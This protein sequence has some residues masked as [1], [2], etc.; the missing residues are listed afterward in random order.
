[1]SYLVK[2]LRLGGLV[3][4]DVVTIMGGEGLSAYEIAPELNEA[5]EA[6]WKTPWGDSGDTD[7]LR[8]VSEPFSPEGG[9]KVL[10]GN[11]G[12]GVIKISAVDPANR[13]I[14]APAVV[15]ESQDDLITAFKRGELDKDFVAVVRFQGPCA[16]GMP[17]LHKMT[18]PLGLL[19]DRGFK[20]ALVTDGRMSGASGKVPAAIHIS[21]E[22]KNSGL[23]SK[24]QTGDMIYF[25]AEAGI[26][27]VEVSEE[28]LA[29][30]PCAVQ[31]PEYLNLGRNL[32]GGFRKMAD[33]SEM[34]ATVFDFKP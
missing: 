8:P 26:V 22:A 11:F 16:N 27:R 31:S 23:I 34:G 7:V 1:M 5:G 28:E 24:I 2:E 17:E 12:K 19:Q 13:K 30:R 10:N 25:D 9:L 29:A 18:P 4:E 3:N 21:P 33:V 15:F 14:V 32:F 6:E 20:V